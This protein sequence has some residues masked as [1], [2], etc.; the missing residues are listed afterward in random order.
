V[1][2]DEPEEEK[3]LY[4]PKTGMRGTIKE[5]AA[6]FAG[7]IREAAQEELRLNEP[8]FIDYS[9]IYPEGGNVNYGPREGFAES[10]GL[11]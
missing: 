4:D 11:D 2:D 6:H 8:K 7:R 9:G 1:S 10:G 5:F 3:I